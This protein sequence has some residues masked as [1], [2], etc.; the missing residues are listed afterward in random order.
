VLIDRVNIDTGDDC[1][2]PKTNVPDKTGKFVP[3]RNLTVRNSRL[4]SRSFGVKWGTETH[5]DMSDILFDS[6]Q[7]HNAHH[8]IG[9]DWR[10][11]SHLTNAVFSNIN[12][13]RMSWVGSGSYRH[14]N[15]MGAAQAI[16]ITNKGN[17]GSYLLGPNETI[18]SVS[19]VRFE[20]ITSVTENS[21]VFVSTCTRTGNSTYDSH[22]LCTEGLPS[23]IHNIEF[24]N[25]VAVIEQLPSNNAS[26]GPHPSHDDTTGMKPIDSRGTGLPVDAFFVEMA[27]NVTFKDCSALF[28]GKSSVSQDCLLEDET[29]PNSFGQCLRF[30]PGFVGDRTQRLDSC[31]PPNAPD[32]PSGLS[33]RLSALSILHSK[34]VFVWRVCMGAQVA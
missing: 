30:G 1:I 6:I 21:A 14:Q 24:V 3:L 8:G 15:W 22:G 26:N 20:N 4:R 23:T 16:S 25:V 7:I 11:A 29:C 12:L 5:G 19:H 31:V 13:L 17:N 2:T 9:I 28:S 34:S 27:T 18:G 10:G 33:G 32:A